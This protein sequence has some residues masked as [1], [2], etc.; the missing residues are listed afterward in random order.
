MTRFPNGMKP[1][2]AWDS[3]EY[4]CLNTGAKIND[5]ALANLKKSVFLVIII[6]SKLV[7]E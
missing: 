3:T 1:R 6:K 7:V 2:V 5:H 4:E